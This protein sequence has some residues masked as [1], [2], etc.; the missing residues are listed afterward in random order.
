MSSSFIGILLAVGALFA[1][2]FGDFFIQKST[3]EVGTWKALFYIGVPGTV[4]LLPFVWNEIT[5][6]GVFREFG[7]LLLLAGLVAFLA[8]LFDFEALKQGKIAI[9]EPILSLELLI[10]VALG[11]L[12][13]NEELS[14]LQFLLI[15]VVFIGVTLSITEHHTHLHYHRRI[16]EKGAML[17]GIG[18]IGMAL[19]NFMVG[20]ASQETSPL[21]TIWFVWIFFTTACFIYLLAKGELKTAVSDIKR[22]PV[23]LGA[24]SVLDTLG[25]FLFASSVKYIPIS[26]ATTISEGFVALAVF[27]GI[28]VNREKLRWHQVA[29]AGIVVAGVLLLSAVSS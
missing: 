4:F 15:L 28:F 2:G 22:Y 21:L 18:A 6:T 11:V 9:V 5:T 16:F 14:L 20:R 17:A 19:T 1:W 3:R 8:G 12:F 25:W 13:A 29:G 24:Q 23:V 27:L 10:T 7:L 26:I